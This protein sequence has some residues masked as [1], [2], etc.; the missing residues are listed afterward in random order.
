MHRGYIKFYRKFLEWEWYQ[1]SNCVRLFLHLLLKANFKDNRWQGTEVKRG[2]LITSINHLSKE[3][4]LSEQQ[5]RSTIKKLI[6]TSEITSKATNKFTIITIEK[7]SFYQSQEEEITNNLTSN[8]TNE[9]QTNNKQITNNQQQLKNVKKDNKEKKENN[10]KNTLVCDE[11]F[12]SFWQMYDKK[13]DRENCIKKWIKISGTEKELIFKNLPAYIN[14]TSE[15]KYRK[16]PLTWLNGKCWNDDIIDKKTE[17]KSNEVVK[18]DMD[19]SEIAEILK[20]RGL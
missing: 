4:G 14:S 17:N 7:Y 3:T 11:Q 9:Q 20:R 8:T 15:K 19:T 13:V 6:S 2:Q 16:N 1:D 12:E 10:N 5:V 18:D